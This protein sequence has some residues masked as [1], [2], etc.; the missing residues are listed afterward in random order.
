MFC[1]VVRA[2]PSQPD[3]IRQQISKIGVQGNITVYMPSGQEF[4]GSVSRIDADDFSVDEVDQRRE[5]TLR[6]GDVK[7][8]RS[9]YP[10][11]S[12]SHAHAPRPS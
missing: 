4:Y 11:R 2:Q 5:V 1:G 3:K 10:R 7:N 12:A 6:Y 9:G 8:V